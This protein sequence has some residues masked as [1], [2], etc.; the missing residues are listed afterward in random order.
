MNAGN[1]CNKCSQS[2][3]PQTSVR[4]WDGRD[5]CRRCV[6]EACPKLV[7]YALAHDVLEET[8]VYDGKAALRRSLRMYALIA[9]VFLAL[10][11]LPW[12]IAGD[13]CMVVT[14][15][16]LVLLIATAAGAIQIPAFLW[17]AKRAVPKV[18]VQDGKVMTSRPNQ[19][20]MSSWTFPLSKCRWYLG[21]VRHD[22]FLRNTVTPNAPAIILVY[23]VHWWGFEV[24]RYKTACGFSDEMRELWEGFLRLAAIPEGRRRRKTTKG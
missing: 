12:L 22:S 24:F 13:L 11:A 3:T 8:M 10:T 15:F 7:D 19:R 9:A 17:M 16:V 20:R 4:L 6:E 14:A 23:P 2:L 5:Y 18:T 21:K 1:R